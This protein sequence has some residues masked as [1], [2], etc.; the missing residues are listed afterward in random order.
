MIYDG[1]TLFNL[2]DKADKCIILKH[3]AYLITK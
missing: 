2:N 1:K 3:D